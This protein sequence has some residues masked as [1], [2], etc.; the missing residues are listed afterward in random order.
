MG[1]EKKTSWMKL[2][3]YALFYFA[4][5]FC[6]LSHLLAINLI[7]CSVGLEMIPTRSAVGFAGSLGAIA[8]RSKEWEAPC[9]RGAGQHGCCGAVAVQWEEGDC[10]SKAAAGQVES[11]SRNS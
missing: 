2:H 1:G 8:G 3:T 11:R 10:R 7:L 6:R 4:V 5:L 9:A